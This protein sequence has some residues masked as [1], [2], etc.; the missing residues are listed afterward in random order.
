MEDLIKT[1][2]QGPSSEIKA[3]RE[4]M[5]TVMRELGGRRSEVGVLS[6]GAD[7]NDPDKR[8][9]IFI[10]PVEAQEGLAQGD[11]IGGDSDVV[12]A[13]AEGFF[14]IRHYT[15][16]TKGKDAAS[17]LELH[18]SQMWKDKG[19]AVTSAKDS[20]GGNSFKFYREPSDHTLVLRFDAQSLYGG[21]YE[22]AEAGRTA[23]T[24]QGI[25]PISKLVP[26]GKETVDRAFDASR[27]KARE[28][29]MPDPNSAMRSIGTDAA[30]DSL[31]GRLEGL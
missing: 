24:E 3:S 15:N 29:K 20:I 25:V 16:T 11:I 2:D 23:Q 9:D 27:E 5:R 1:P 13:T 21:V 14:A 7:P 18:L 26:V 10:A 19:G 12:I 6:I 17:Q 28:L 22:Y 30:A 4:K 31:L 8:V